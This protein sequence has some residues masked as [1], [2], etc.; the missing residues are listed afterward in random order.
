[1]KIPALESEKSNLEKLMIQKPYPYQTIP[2]FK[3]SEML[4]SIVAAS[5]LKEL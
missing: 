5:L 4:R 3:V 1:V 2:W